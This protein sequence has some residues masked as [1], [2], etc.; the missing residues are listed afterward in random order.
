MFVCLYVSACLH[1]PSVYLLVFFSLS[2]YLSNCIILYFPT[3]FFVSQS[4]S[5][6]L[7]YLSHLF[8]HLPAFFS[9]FL[10]CLSNSLDFSLFVYFLCLLLSLSIFVF[11]YHSSV[12]FPFP[13]SLYLFIQSYVSIFFTFALHLYVQ[14]YVCSF[15]LSSVT[16]SI[17]RLFLKGGTPSSQSQPMEW[18][19]GALV[20]ASL[21]GFPS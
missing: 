16:H 12:C 8:V 4:T 17:G 20:S 10:H 21:Y 3:Y 14:S 5:F 15:S 2:I 9:A 7:Y 13:L 19:C 6:F 1:N 18:R 11:L